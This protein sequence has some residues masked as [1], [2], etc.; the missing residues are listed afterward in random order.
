MYLGGLMIYC[1]YILNNRH[2]TT[3]YTGVTNNLH[4]RV[5]EHRERKG[6]SFS[7]RYN[8]TKLVYYEITEDINTAIL[9]EKQLKSGSRQKK[10]DLINSINPG[11]NDLFDEL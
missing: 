10:I 1:V 3:L 6:S 9:R 4:R 11:W 5:I 8:L 2:N 7:K